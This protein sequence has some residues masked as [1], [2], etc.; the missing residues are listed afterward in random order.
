MIEVPDDKDDTSFQ[1]WVAKGSRRY[2]DKE[3][4]QF[5]DST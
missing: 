2:P 3:V 1:K 5:A 4:R